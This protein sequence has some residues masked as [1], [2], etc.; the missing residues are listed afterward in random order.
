MTNTYVFLK[1]YLVFLYV[2][3]CFACM[4]VCT[5]GIHCPWKSIKECPKTL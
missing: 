5:M 2:D 4:Y 1:M 3:R